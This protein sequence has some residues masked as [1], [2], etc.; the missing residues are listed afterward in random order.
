MVINDPCCD[1]C[2]RYIYICPCERRLGVIAS[3]MIE[4]ASALE[5]MAAL[6]VDAARK[7]RTH[8]ILFSELRKD[9]ANERRF[10]NGN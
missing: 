3:S 6:I 4:A 8:S 2:G 9:E 10:D 1:K 7:L 5:D